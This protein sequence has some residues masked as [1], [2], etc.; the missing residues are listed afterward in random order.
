MKLTEGTIYSP[1]ITSTEAQDNAGDVTRR[2]E[3]ARANAQLRGS[4][5]MD[6]AV[7]AAAHPLVG[8]GDV[9]NVS[10]IGAR[11][12]PQMLHAKRC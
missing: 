10:G 4:D 1:L 11:R 6:I 9:F 3:Q 12:G 5:A 7:G 2:Y 8:V